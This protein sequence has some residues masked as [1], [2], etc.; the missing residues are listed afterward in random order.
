MDVVS[1]RGLTPQQKRERFAETATRLFRENGFRE[2]TV[3]DIARESGLSARTFFRYFGT[4]E[5]VLFQDIRE[6]LD[7]L[8]EVLSTQPPS[9]SRWRQVRELVLGAIERLEVPSTD[10]GG[11]I[12]A[13]LHEPVIHGRFREYSDEMERILAEAL[14]VHSDAADEHLAPLLRASVITAIYRSA[15]TIYSERGGSLRDLVNAGFD[16]VEAGNIARAS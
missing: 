9:T 3:D 11:T 1:A 4:K 16:Y 12:T 5:E 2:T 6:I 10:L 7:E 14:V 13:W 8:R 15:L